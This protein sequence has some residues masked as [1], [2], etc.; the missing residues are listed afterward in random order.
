[1]WN[2]KQLWNRQVY[3]RWLS[4]R[5]MPCVDTLKCTTVAEGRGLSDIITP[6]ALA[7]ACGPVRDSVSTEFRYSTLHA[8]ERL[9]PSMRT[10]EGKKMSHKKKKR[11]LWEER[12]VTNGGPMR[13]EKKKASGKCLLHRQVWVCGYKKEVRIREE[14]GL[15]SEWKGNDLKKIRGWIW[16]ERIILRWKREV[17]RGEDVRVLTCSLFQ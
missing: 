6:V 5:V 12:R 11:L 10:G 13:R 2:E 4:V 17:R 15:R 3:R 16:R 9:T 7:T 1:M 14:E 8:E